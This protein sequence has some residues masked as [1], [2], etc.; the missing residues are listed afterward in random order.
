MP[1]TLSNTAIKSPTRLRVDN[2]TQVAVNRTLSGANTRDYF[3]SNKRVWTLEFD[4][5]NT[6]DFG[7]IDALYQ[8]YLITEAAV[9]WIITEG[10]YAT[11]QTNVF[12]D[13]LTRSFQVPGSSYLSDCTL[14]LTEA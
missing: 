6:T 11:S 4:N 3:G 9:T 2:S 7:I 10:N 12:V 13:F 5:L 8:A 14:I 1:F